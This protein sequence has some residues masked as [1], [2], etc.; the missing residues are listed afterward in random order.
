MENQ[1]VNTIPEAAYLAAMIDGEGCINIS[2][3]MAAKGKRL[4][5][6]LELIIANNCHAMLGTLQTRHGGSLHAIRP[7]HWQLRFATQDTMRALA[8][9]YPFLLIKRAQADIAR[10]FY[11]TYGAP[12]T[13]D[14]L[15]ARAELKK[16]LMGR[17]LD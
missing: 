5:Y 11:A 3:R 12:L 15:A 10:A 17:P 1:H 16:K 4:S 13:D 8:C 6:R 9:A 2:S 7:N 14:I